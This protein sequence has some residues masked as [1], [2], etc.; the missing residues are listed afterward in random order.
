[1]APTISYDDIATL[2]NATSAGT[3]PNRTL[4]LYQDSVG[5]ASVQQHI[6]GA[7]D[8]LHF[9][10]GD[11]VWTTTDP[12]AAPAVQ[13]LFLIYAGVMVLTVLC[14]GM[15]LSGFDITM[16]DVALRRSE[17]GQVYMR[18]INTFMNEARLLANQLYR[19]AI[20]KEGAAVRE[21]PTYRGAVVSP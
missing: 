7:G 14:G 12:V 4:T 6:G 21:V 1:M 9:L 11:G 5:E 20:V 8:Y 15:M 18:V 16:S 10:L 19:V 13:R 2:I 3:T 17:R